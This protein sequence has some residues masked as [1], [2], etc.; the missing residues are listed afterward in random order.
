MSLSITRKDETTMISF[1]TKKLEEPVATISSQCITRLFIFPYMASSSETYDTL[2][3]DPATNNV[4][5]NP[6]LSLDANVSKSAAR[7]TKQ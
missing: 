1:E 2:A 3:I 7:T 4:P 5:L 6:Q